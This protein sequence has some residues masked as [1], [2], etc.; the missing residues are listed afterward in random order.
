MAPAHLARLLLLAAALPLLFV[1]RAADAGDAGVCLGMDGSD[2]M[3]PPAIVNLLKRKGITMVRI[4]DTNRTVLQ[5]FA[6]QNIKVM[7]ALP[8]RDL[9]SG[10]GQDKDSA[11]NWVKSNIVPYYPATQINGV[12]V[13]NEVFQEAPDL[14][15]RLLPA[16]TNVQAALARLGL[17]DAIKVTTPISFESVTHSSPPSS[18]VFQDNIAQSVMGP[19]IDVLHNTGSY[20]AVNCYPYIA[21]AKNPSKISQDYATFGPNAAGV[22]DKAG[23]DG[24]SGSRGCPTK[25]T[26]CVANPTVG[27]GRLQAALDWA[28]SNGADCSTIQQ[29]KVCYAPNTLVAHASYSFN[30]YYQRKNQASGT[31]NFNGAASIVYKPSSSICNPNPSW[32][33]AKPEVG[34]VRL[35]SALDYACRTC[36][37]CS[38]IQQG[39]Q[40]FDPNT[41]VAHATYAFNDYYQTAGRASGSCD[42]NGAASIVY[43]QPTILFFKK[44]ARPIVMGQFV[45]QLSQFNMGP[46]CP[47]KAEG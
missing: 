5:A 23:G 31:C 6:N 2:L 41:K 12:A 1:S 11:L 32:S 35:Q 14:T 25:A 9:A 24:G 43:Q 44:N 30:D 15:S 27:N 45:S 42:F 16:M 39:A 33:V 37:D 26:W 29:E 20:L 47:E 18:A 19:M 46:V 13:G 4:Y 34:D 36:T 8:N 38:A 3:D 7:V 17:A 22:I 21:W 40:C 10:V 28:C